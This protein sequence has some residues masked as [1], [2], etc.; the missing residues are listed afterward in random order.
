MT[1]GKIIYINDDSQVYATC[2]FNGD[3][4]PHRHGEDILEH[5]QD[6]LFQGYKSYSEFVGKLNRKYFGYD[7]EL[8]GTCFG[9]TNRTIDITDNWTD[10]LY[11][12]NN[13]SD[14][15]IIATK[16]NEKHLPSRALGIIHYQAIISIVVQT[17][18]K[19]LREL[20]ILSKKEF[21]DVMNRLRGASDLQEQ[22]NKLF[23]D[24]R[25]NIENDFCNAAALQISHENSVVF[26]LKRI[27]R[28]QYEYIDYFIY[29]LDYGRKYEEGM[30]TEADGRNID[31]HSSELLYDFI[32]NNGVIC[33]KE[34]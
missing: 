26:L 1:R 25:E 34:V 14:E 20:D 13:S 17:N 2:E 15:W 23:H 7:G 3:M 11:I 12:I 27:M 28:D 9:Y 4:H 32:L 22:V 10:Y 8:I 30:I 18:K 24:S 16:G 29:E 19:D 31:I 21:V 5:F 33:Q 6:G